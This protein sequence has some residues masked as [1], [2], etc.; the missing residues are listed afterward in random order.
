MKQLKE[1]LTNDVLLG[2]ATGFIAG[3]ITMTVI[4]LCLLSGIINKLPDL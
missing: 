1:R 4:T 3:T 2:I